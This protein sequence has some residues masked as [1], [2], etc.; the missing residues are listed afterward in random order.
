M[1]EYL[2]ELYDRFS[3]DNFV[4]L[5]LYEGFDTEEVFNF[6]M[7]NCKLSALVFQERIENEY[8]KQISVDYII[9]DDL[10]ELRQ[11]M[12]YKYFLNKN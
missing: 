6:I 1:T 7:N 12:F 3:F 2:I 11:E 4:R 9:A 5:L 10:K 8:Y